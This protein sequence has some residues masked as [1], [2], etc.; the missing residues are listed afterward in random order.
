MG[1]LIAAATNTHLCQIFDLGA[2]L[3]LGGVCQLVAQVLRAWMPP[4]GL[5]VVTFCLVAL[6]QAYNDTQA[7]AFVAEVN[8]A[9]RWLAFIH[10]CYMCGCLVGPFAATAIAS[11]GDVSR[12]YLF[13]TVPVGI[14]VL[15]I[16][17]VSWA[18]WDS[19][20][21]KRKNAATD[22]DRDMQPVAE[23]EEQNVSRNSSAIQLIKATLG[24][25]SVWLL[26]MFYFFYIGSQITMSG[27]VVEYLVEVRKG[28]LSKMGYVPAG[29]NGGCL[30]GRLL[31]AEPTYRL[32]ERKMVTIYCVIALAL[33]IVFWL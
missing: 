12:W 30:L 1:W 25:K 32:G 24:R 2:M 17:L 14:C 15:N 4:F 21:L 8:G 33:Q 7:N 22:T 5:F 9:H 19:L 16:A 23:E 28:E 26:S 10:A 3:V 31:L 20:S 29:F 11:A 18:F 6:G 27:W 13:Y